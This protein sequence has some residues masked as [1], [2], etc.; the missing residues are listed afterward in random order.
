MERKI[1]VWLGKALYL[2]ESSNSVSITTFWRGSRSQPHCISFA[3]YSYAQGNSVKFWKFILCSRGLPIPYYLPDLSAYTSNG[4]LEYSIS[5][6]KFLP[7]YSIPA[8]LPSPKYP[9]YYS[10][11]LPPT[12]KSITT[13]LVAWAPRGHCPQFLLLFTLLY[14]QSISK[15]F[16]FCL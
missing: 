7:S 4:Y 11:V 1:Q 8:L 2:A 12:G 9:N 14:S 13:Y 10:S 6:T 3:K 15:S 5:R 16:W